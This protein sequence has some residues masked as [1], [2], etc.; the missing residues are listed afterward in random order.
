MRIVTL[1]SLAIIL[2]GLRADGSPERQHQQLCNE[3]DSRPL[4]GLHTDVRGQVA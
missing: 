1:S 3:P 2:V 4:V